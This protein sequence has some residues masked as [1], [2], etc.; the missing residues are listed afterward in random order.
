MDSSFVSLWLDWSGIG[1]FCFKV[2]LSLYSFL[3]FGLNFMKF[4]CHFVLLST[5][6]WCWWM[7]FIIWE[8]VITSSLLN[9]STMRMAWLK[10]W[11][12]N[13]DFTGITFI[14]TH[15]FYDICSHLIKF[16]WGRDEYRN[17][18]LNKN[19]NFYQLFTFV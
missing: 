4:K 18:N 17:L 1:L 16:E 10:T 15:L 9:L 12:N 5:E 2:G 13:N 14:A 11:I 7:S 8:F 3:L 19:L 6:F